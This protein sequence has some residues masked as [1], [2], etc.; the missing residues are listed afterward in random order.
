MIRLVGT[1][2]EKLYV[3]VSGGADSMAV[4]DFLSRTNRDIRV[5]H[6][7]HGTAHAEEASALIEAHCWDKGYKLKTFKLERERD[8]KESIEE[9]WRNERYRIFSDLEGPV[10]TCHHL[11][12]VIEW[13]LFSAIHGEGR[14]MP[15]ERGNVIRPF[16][17]T[18][19]QILRRWCERKNVPFVEDPGNKDER[20]MRSIIRHEIL[21]QALRVNPG[22]HKVVFKLVKQKYAL[23]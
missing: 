6:V 1:L 22:L 11:D 9:Y 2:P 12:D 13:Y 19:R 23:V 5:V 8:P 17:L 14:I 16:L 18:P 7:N 15:Y 4:L 21:P 10:I 3:A 20:Y